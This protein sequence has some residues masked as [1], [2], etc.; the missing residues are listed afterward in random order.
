MPLNNIIENNSLLRPDAPAISF[1]GVSRN[2]AE[3]AQHIRKLVSRL[4]GV[5]G[6]GPQQRVAIL[7]QNSSEYVE[8]CGVSEVSRL[9]ADAI[10]EMHHIIAAR[11]FLAKR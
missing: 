10:Q 1:N 5:A 9:T 7:S 8:C 3:H 2:F 11:E 4:T 6:V